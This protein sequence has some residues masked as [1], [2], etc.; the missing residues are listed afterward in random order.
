MGDRT[1]DDKPEPSLELPS[2]FRRRRRAPARGEREPEARRETA[3]EPTTETVTAA[4]PLSAEPL[5]AEPPEPERTAVTTPGPPPERATETR[6]P[7][8]PAVDDREPAAG[9]ASP[10][11]RE[12]TPARRVAARRRPRQASRSGPR[13]PASIAA[14]L[15]GL[16]V[17]LLGAVLTYGGLQGCEFLRG[18]DSCGGGAGV[19]L[20]VG[21]L[22]VLVVAGGGLLAWLGVSDPRSTSFLGVGVTT[23]VAMVALLETVFS[24]WM[25]VV[26]PALTAAAYLLAWWVTTRVVDPLD[27]GP[28]V[29]VR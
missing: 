29:D 1:R 18:T 12:R 4:E 16:L 23:V 8:R 7:A 28:G 6:P 15:T 25:F 17:G 21:I 9:T 24:A 27:D 14:L 10:P 20:L 13:F 19:L 3:P 5:S 11:E 26:A 2:L 22:A